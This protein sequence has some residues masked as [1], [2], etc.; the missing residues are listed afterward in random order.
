[1]FGGNSFEFGQ[2]RWGNCAGCG[3]NVNLNNHLC[4]EIVIHIPVVS[5]EEHTS[6]LN[7]ATVVDDHEPKEG[8]SRRQLADAWIDVLIELGAYAKA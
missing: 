4:P 6:G 1:M 8:P 3:C 7:H 5:R 2:P